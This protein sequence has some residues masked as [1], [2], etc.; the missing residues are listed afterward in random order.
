MTALRTF[1]AAARLG[2]FKQAAEEL[3]VS[4]TAVS[5]QIRRLEDEIGHSLFLRKTRKVELN[6]GGARL[7]DVVGQAF[8]AVYAEVDRLITVDRRR[9]DLALGPFVAARWLIPRLSSFWS[10]HPRMD[11]RLHHS[12]LEVDPDSFTA[13]LAIA[14]GHGDWPGVVSHRMFGLEATPM[15]S[16]ELIARRGPVDDV[17]DLARYQIIHYRDRS[18][19]REWLDRAGRRDFRFPEETVI[20]DANVAHQA[21]LQGQG[22]ILGMRPFVEDDIAAGRLVCPFD[23]SVELKRA[24][25]LVARRQ[26]LKDPHVRHVHDWLIAQV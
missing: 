16:P 18:D 8:G 5:H 21:A 17:G 19:W 2:S 15:A 23:L 6:E 20:D 25:H 22:V 1:E 26:R 3:G 24:Y 9:V 4:P 13:D 11:L 12:P 10:A 7:A 14:W